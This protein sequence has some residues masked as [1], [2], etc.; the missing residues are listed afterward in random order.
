MAFSKGD[1]M[2]YTVC[3]LCPRNCAVDRTTS[4][5]F[6]G[7]TADLRIARAALHFWEEPCISGKNGSGT[8]FFV[9]C[10]LRC[11]YC[12][13]SVISTGNTGARVS[14]ERLSEI[15][16]ELQEKGAENINLVTPTH[17]VL[18]II[19][20]IKLAKSRGLRLPI[21]YNCGGYESVETLKLLDEFVDVYLPD[22]KYYDERFAIKYS[23]A[24]SYKEIA[25]K[26]IEEM[27]RQVGKPQFDEKGMMVKGVIVRH[28]CLPTL[29]D[30]SKR[31]L[32]FLHRTFGDSI[33]ISIMSQY[34]PTDFC[35]CEELQKPLDRED[36][37]EI[38]E[39]CEAI[40]IEQGFT[41][42]E[43]CAEESFIPPFDL[44]GVE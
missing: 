5:G 24:P 21:V 44:T 4:K 31:V 35:R 2:D 8:V 10:N 20:A 1:F 34:T 30:D 11:C 32:K 18:Q 39:Y 29:T 14:T 17:F 42:D 6:C 40:G 9:G 7:E 28:L 12:Q 15:F 38:L 3:R 41:Q 27:V 43:G 26:A 22:F 16:L 36:Y 25:E 37:E 19:E 23:N 13:N 33:Y